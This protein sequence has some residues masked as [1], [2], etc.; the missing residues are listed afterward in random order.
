MLEQNFLVTRWNFK[1][2]QNEILINI[3][4]ETYVFYQTRNV[5]NAHVNSDETNHAH[6]NIDEN[7]PSCMQNICPK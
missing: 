4:T 6:V 5:V 3:T 7:N 1:H 2:Q